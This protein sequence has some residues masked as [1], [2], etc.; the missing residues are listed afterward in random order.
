MNKKYQQVL[1]PRALFQSHFTIFG[2]LMHTHTH[3]LAHSNPAGYLWRRRRR[4]ARLRGHYSLVP[5]SQGDTTLSCQGKSLWRVCLHSSQY[6]YRPDRKYNYSIS[7]A[8]SHSCVFVCVGGGGGGG[9]GGRVGGIHRELVG[10]A[11]RSH[12]ASWL[13]QL[14]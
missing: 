13:K 4:E 1:W 7:F 11:A 14:L 2:S 6:Y 8:C 9:G 10:P 12:P 3:A 5:A